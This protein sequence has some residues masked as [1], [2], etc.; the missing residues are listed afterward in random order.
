MAYHWSG[1]SVSDLDGRSN[2]HN[3]PLS[4]SP[5][6]SNILTL[7]NSVKLR[8]MKRL[9]KKNLK[10]IEIGSCV[11]RKSHLHN[12]QVQ[13]ETASADVEAAANFPED[14]PD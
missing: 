14:L 7:F 6:Q 9:Q 12:T 11:S 8:E 4:L 2:S 5:I 3:I 10:P 13:S 1:E